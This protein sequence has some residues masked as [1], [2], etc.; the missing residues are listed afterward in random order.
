LSHSANWRVCFLKDTQNEC[1]ASSLL[2]PFMKQI[3]FC[4]KTV[5]AVLRKMHLSDIHPLM[6]TTYKIPR[7][8]FQRYLMASSG[9]WIWLGRYLKIFQKHSGPLKCCTPHLYRAVCFNR[10]IFSDFFFY[11]DDCLNWNTLS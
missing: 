7:P 5:H 4:W 6:Y 9:I 10:I 8:F 1:T 2:S 11:G 3:S